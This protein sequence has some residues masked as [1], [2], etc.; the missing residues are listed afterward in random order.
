MRRF[1][2]NYLSLLLILSCSQKKKESQHT[3]PLVKEKSPKEL[4][5][6]PL[7]VIDAGH[8]GRDP[9][10]VNDSLK[11]YEKNI[12]RNIVDAL[13]NEI[14]TTKL[15]IVQTRLG[16]ES[17]HRHKRIEMANPLEPDLLLTVHINSDSRD[18]TYNGFEISYNDSLLKE[19]VNEDTIKFFNPFKKE[20]HRYSYIIQNKVHKVFPKMRIRGVKPRKDDIWMIYAV[21]YPSILFEFGY[22]T[23][24]KDALV[25]R[26]KKEV[27]KLAVALKISLY[28]ILGIK[29]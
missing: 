15:S 3:P 22:I 20:L 1:F 7:L 18:T 6:K 5:T 27:K 2:V 24:T 10:G 17:I 26:D 4:R 29:S 8:G 9:G 14:D 11:L 16:D 21:H 12:T 23:N 25:M 19:V 28:E 13:I